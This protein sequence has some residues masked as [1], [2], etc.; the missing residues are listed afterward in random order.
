MSDFLSK[1]PA[2]KKF[3]R[4]CCENRTKIKHKTKFWEENA[5][6]IVLFEKKIIFNFCS[7]FVKKKKQYQMTIYVLF[8][9]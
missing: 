5:A 2:G 9:T 7:I 8:F 4:N 1:C 3:W 6:K